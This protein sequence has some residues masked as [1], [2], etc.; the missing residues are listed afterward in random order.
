MAGGGF[1]YRETRGICT[2]TLLEPGKIA[3]LFSEVRN[4][5]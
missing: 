5:G 1:H 4:L 2:I 3:L